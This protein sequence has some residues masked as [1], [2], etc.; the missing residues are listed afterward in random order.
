M[1]AGRSTTC[2]GLS[3]PRNAS[4]YRQCS[5][6][7]WRRWPGAPRQRPIAFHARG[8]RQPA[9]PGRPRG[10]AP[11]YLATLAGTLRSSFESTRAQI[12]AEAFAASL[13]ESVAGIKGFAISPVGES[14][15]DRAELDVEL[16]FSDRNERQRFVLVR[17]SGGWLVARIDK[18]DTVKPPIPYDAPVFDTGASAEGTPEEKPITS[19]GPQSLSAPP[20]PPP[21]PFSPTQ[22]DNPVNG[23]AGR[24]VN[25]LLENP[26]SR[27]TGIGTSE[28]VPHPGAE[29]L[30]VAVVE[31]PLK[32]HS[33]RS[34]A[35]PCGAY[36]RWGRAIASR[37]RR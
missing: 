2:S 11:A 17:Q 15:P 9:V 26:V 10:D 23:D 8:R 25:R 3:C 33:R 37:P 12:G 31:L 21:P 7:L 36:G 5:S 1:Q 6:S 14:S 27:Q 13:R 30:L 24:G 22:I 28:I 35:G 34:T 19:P 4:P 20:I 32:T 16:V 18:A 29:E